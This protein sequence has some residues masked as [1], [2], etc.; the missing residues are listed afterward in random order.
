MI[1]ICNNL[2]QIEAL[3]GECIIWAGIGM[4]TINNKTVDF[5]YKLGVSTVI[6][7]I[8]AGKK[9]KKYNINKA[10]IYT[11]HEFCFLSKK[12]CNRMR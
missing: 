7:S 3:L 5:L 2:G 12:Y 4:N 10:R 1:V 9:I 8:E 6:S 11:C